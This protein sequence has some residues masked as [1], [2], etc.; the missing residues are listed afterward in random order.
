[1]SDIYF[2]DSPFVFTHKPEGHD[3]FKSETI[4]KINAYIEHNLCTIE[5]GKVTSN[6][7]QQFNGDTDPSYPHFRFTE[8]WNKAIIWESVDA[9]TAA[10]F[11]INPNIPERPVHYSIDK[12]WF[13]HYDNGSFIEPHAHH[14]VDISGIYIIHSEGP[15]PTRFMNNMNVGNWR[16]ARTIYETDHLTEGTVILFPSH[17]THWTVPSVGERYTISFDLT[18]QNTQNFNN[19]TPE[20]DRQFEIAKQFMIGNEGT[21]PTL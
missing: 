4:N 1:M 15:N 14:S 3:R 7:V 21:I 10:L 13:N 11:K 20:Q 6:F 9:L 8:E 17:L 19:T 12:L 5:D 2:F 16:Y 18:V